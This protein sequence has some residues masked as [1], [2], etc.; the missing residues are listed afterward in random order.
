MNNADKYEI[1]A[2]LFYD[3]ANHF[4]IDV[5]KS[6]AVIGLSPLIQETNGSFVAIQFAEVGSTVEQHK[7]FGTAE[8]EK[9]VGPLLSPISGKILA[10]NQEVITTPR[11]IND[12]PYDGGWLVEM[13]ILNPSELEN[14]ITG[15]QKIREWFAAELQKFDEKGWIAK[16]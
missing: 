12:Q 8:A 10:I 15:E 9:H 13:E 11:L 7:S 1:R 5:A 3:P 4:W 16:P 14:M 6:H 2:D